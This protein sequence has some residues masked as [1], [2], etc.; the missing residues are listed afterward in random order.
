M[1]L[2]RVETRERLYLPI[3]LPVRKLHLA[4]KQEQKTPCVH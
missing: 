2:V 4:V 3:T 1:D